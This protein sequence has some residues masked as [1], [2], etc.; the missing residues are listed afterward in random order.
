LL[1][2]DL[3]GIDSPWMLDDWRSQIQSLTKAGDS[4]VNRLV[5]SSDV[6]SYIVLAFIGLCALDSFIH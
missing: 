1:I 3:L 4:A 6:E 5:D 2:P